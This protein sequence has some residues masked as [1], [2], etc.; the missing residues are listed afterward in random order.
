MEQLNALEALKNPPHGG[1]DGRFLDLI[2]N[3]LLG[4]GQAGLQPEFG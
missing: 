2:R 1:V 4:L 3:R